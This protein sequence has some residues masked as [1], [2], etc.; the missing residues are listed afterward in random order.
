VQ[1]KVKVSADGF[2]AELLDRCC[3]EFAVLEASFPLMHWSLRFSKNA[4]IPSVLLK[5]KKENT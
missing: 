2:A 1:A 5:A 3:T 4:F